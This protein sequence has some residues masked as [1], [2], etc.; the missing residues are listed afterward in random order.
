MEAASPTAPRLG[1]MRVDAVDGFGGWSVGLAAALTSEEA[2]G[3]ERKH[4]ERP[5]A[6]TTTVT[7][8]IL[9]RDWRRK[10]SPLKRTEAE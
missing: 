10:R 4:I 3:K 1:R 9:G 6:T 2:A 7:A 5:S 8:N